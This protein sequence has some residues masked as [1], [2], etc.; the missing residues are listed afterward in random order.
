MVKISLNLGSQVKMFGPLIQKIVLDIV[1]WNENKVIIVLNV[2]N[3]NE[4]RVQILWVQELEWKQGKKF[5]RKRTG[6]PWNENVD[7]LIQYENTDKKIELVIYPPLLWIFKKMLQSM[8]KKV[9]DLRY[10]FLSTTL[11]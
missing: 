5:Q 2:M 1:N 3:W 6:E 7:P 10:W 8:K 4:N 9:Q 11:E